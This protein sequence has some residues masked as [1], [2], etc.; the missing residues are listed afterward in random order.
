MDELANLAPMLEEMR[1][2][3]SIVRPSKFWEALNERNL[4]QLDEAGFERFKQTINRNYFQFLPA[5]PRN[6][7]FRAVLSSWLRRPR[8]RVLTARLADRSR[9]FADT[10]AS[11]SRALQRYKATLYTSYVAMLW[12]YVRGRERLGLLD[13]LQEPELGRPI[14]FEY[15]GRRIS[16]DLCNSVL[17]LTSVIE[18]IPEPL[19]DGDLVIELGSGYGRLAWAYL[20]A[21]PG[22]RYVLVDIPP[23]LAIAEEYLTRLFPERE[24]FRFR[25]F[26]RHE[27][28]AGELERVRIA[29]LT[30]NQLELIPALGA[31]LF[32]NISS[33]HEMRPDQIAHYLERVGVHCSG[34]F[35]SKQWLRSVNPDDGVVIEREDYPIPPDW[36]PVFDR[37]HPVQ[38]QFFEAF[39]RLPGAE[40]P[41]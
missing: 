15:R 40:P 33:L 5:D 8:P 4:H 22:I 41:G 3:P 27:E 7:Q 25:H 23:A 11:G 18:A 24:V 21:F 30:P 38:T 9:L 2:A 10:G 35:Y 31:R 14:S 36:K 34:Y 20:E 32:L 17:E 19:A 12:E 6:E 1:S 37:V 39:Y 29:F 13:R 28:I 16:E 26:E